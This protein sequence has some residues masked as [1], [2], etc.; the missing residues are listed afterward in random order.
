MDKI[1]Y[2]LDAMG[3]GI[4]IGGWYGYSRNNNGWSHIS[5]GVASYVTNGK[6]RLTD[7]FVAKYLYDSSTA[8]SIGTQVA[9][10]SIKTKMVFPVTADQ[11]V[12][13]KESSTAE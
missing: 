8:H 11:V 6:D 3:T 1:G 7:V 13:F 4:V 10:V 12:T 5:I 9:D 2:H